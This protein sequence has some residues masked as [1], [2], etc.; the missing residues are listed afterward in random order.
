MRST[1]FV[2][3]MCLASCDDNTDTSVCPG[4]IGTRSEIAA[5][6]RSDG[7]LELLALTLG[8]SNRI[9]ADPAVYL[10]IVTDMEA[11]QRSA[12]AG[13]SRVDY[14]P[15]DDGKTMWLQFADAVA[16][17]AE[18]GRYT[19][20][21]CLNDFYGMQSVGIERVDLTNTVSAIVTFKGNYNM[22]ALARL[23]AV[24]PGIE[25]AQ[26]DP[27]SGHG[28]TI[29]MAGQGTTYEYVIDV[30]SGDCPKG[31]IQHSARYYRTTAAGAATLQG[32]WSTSD[33]PAPE[34]FRRLC[35]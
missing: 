24:L 23:Y 32:V 30:G 25:T 31:C 14:V 4:V 15:R 29:C 12:P 22:A 19:E 11:I 1:L 21:D 9:T 16:P 2:G 10:R 28:S 18:A 8:S 3:L 20:W 34:W 17:L 7:N 27:R 13:F 26:N 33:G 5:T 35:P 6:P